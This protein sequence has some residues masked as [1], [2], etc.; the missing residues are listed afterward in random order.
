MSQSTCLLSGNQKGKTYGLRQIE[1]F[2][3][4]LLILLPEK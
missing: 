2:T 4:K 3:E 1:P